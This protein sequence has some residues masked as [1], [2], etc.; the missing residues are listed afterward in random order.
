MKFSY[1]LLKKLTTKLPD[2]E[3]FVEK[4]NF[5]AFETEDVDD[6][7]LEIAI[8][9]N[10]YSDA[11]SHWGIAKVAAAVFSG[12]AKDLSKGKALKSQLKNP[13]PAVKVASRKRSPRYMARYFELPRIPAT[14]VWMREV[15]TA[16]GIR[17]I[18][19]VVD[20]MNYVMLEV[21]Q[22]LHAFDAE[23]IEGVIQVRLAK[24]K[25][26][27]RTI[28]GGEY[29]LSSEDL[30]IADDKGPLAIAG[31]KGG[32]RAE[33]VGYSKKIV[34]ETANFDSIGIYKTARSINLFTDASIRFS[35]GMKPELTEIA[36]RRATELLKEI[37]KAKVGDL[38]DINSTRPR[39]TVLKFDIKEFNKLT[40][41]DLKEKQA[42][43][44]LKRLGFG[45]NG[46]L[47][48]VPPMRSDIERMADLTEEIVN[49]YGYEKLP[50]TAPLI[51]L[52]PAKKENKVLIKDKARE[53]LRGFGLDEVYNYS[54]VSRKDLT[55]Y[56]DPKWW[57]AVPLRNPIS[58]EFQYLRPSLSIWLLRNIE[59]NLRFYDEV[60]VFEIGKE[61][62]EKPFGG[63]QGKE[64]KMKEGL[65]LGIALGS[66]KGSSTILEL[67]G[68]ID[69]LLRSL[70]LVD[71]FFSEETWD[72]RYLEAD[73]TLRIES[74]DHHVIGRLGAAVGDKGFSFAQI[75][76][77]E[78]TPL[79]AKEKEFLPLP[80]YPSIIRDLSV[81][82][83]ADRRVAEIQEL[84]EHSSQLLEDVDLADWF[85]DSHHVG[86][87]RKSLTFRLTFQSENR[88]L[89]D[90]EVNEEMKKITSALVEVDAEIR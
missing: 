54:F 40:G 13:A 75:D 19:S 62:I 50:T 41:L 67:K 26:E 3:E 42:L 86:A 53:V 22:P 69:Q 79:I 35:H 12:K 15:L 82:V 24:R 5:H 17:P 39:K 77:D 43:D 81:A 28:D 87:G 47:V 90:K 20:I 46:K 68:L 60:R 66:K 31:V 70:G 23:K 85:E 9:S 83:D 74:G 29:K 7:T 55:K 89:T 32:K 1:T 6:D 76:L 4:F 52:S 56:G 45:I 10:R 11:S 80:K 48:T 16:S 34:V 61:F 8:P 84:I 25:E 36:M 21:G 33:V 65:T 27:I 72:I 37:C 58:S 30:V 14:P 88:T 49:L 57:G 2:K 38:T 71:Y 44:Y 51:P 59:S 64:G 78:L 63:A 18:N 73:T